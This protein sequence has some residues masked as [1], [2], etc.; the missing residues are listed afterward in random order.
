MA[1]AFSHMMFE[2]WVVEYSYMLNRRHSLLPVIMS[3]LY[4]CA[5]IHSIYKLQLI[6]TCIDITCQI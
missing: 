1:L 4:V 2:S 3:N 6:P 5:C